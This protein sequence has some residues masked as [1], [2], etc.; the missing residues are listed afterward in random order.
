MNPRPDDDN[1][2]LGIANA[3]MEAGNYRR[4]YSVQSTAYTFTRYAQYFLYL[5][6]R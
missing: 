4:N 1:S 5:G 2:G 3:E 6:F